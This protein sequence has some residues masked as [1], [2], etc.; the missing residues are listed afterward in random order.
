MRWKE[1]H[2]GTW[3]VLPNT[4]WLNIDD[5]G[6]SVFILVLCLR[7]GIS[8]I[9]R[10]YHYWNISYLN[11]LLL[12]V[13][14]LAIHSSQDGWWFNLLRSSLNSHLLSSGESWEKSSRIIPSLLFCKTHILSMWKTYPSARASTSLY[15]IFLQTRKTCSP[16][17]RYRQSCRAHELASC[18]QAPLC[19]EKCTPSVGRCDLIQVD[20]IVFERISS[21]S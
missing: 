1:E 9:W 18:Q 12:Y 17:E 15:D 3:K 4:Y 8:Q 16:L 2:K 5:S 7:L 20:K 14:W 13:F 21:K 19:N 6:L 10:L 11:F